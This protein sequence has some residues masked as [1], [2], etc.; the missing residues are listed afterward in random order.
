MLLI[1]KVSISRGFGER[2]VCEDTSRSVR[3]ASPCIP[4][5]P[6]R[7]EALLRSLRKKLWF[8]DWT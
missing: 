2:D 8:L 7:M 5:S 3:G 4:L 6:Q 1:E